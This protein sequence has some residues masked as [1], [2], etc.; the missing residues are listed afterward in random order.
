M[1]PANEPRDQR[2]MGA[3]ALAW[4]GGVVVLLSAFLPEGGIPI[5]GRTFR[6]ILPEEWPQPW[7]GESP[8]Q[9]VPRW[10]PEDVSALLAR[11]DS[12]WHA[13]TQAP[14]MEGSKLPVEQAN[15]AE[16]AQDP[17]VLPMIQGA[18]DSVALTPNTS[19][20]N[21]SQTQ[22][23]PAS[24][25]SQKTRHVAPAA[26]DTEALPSA[27]QLVIPET[28]RPQFS[29]LFSRL[30][31][32]GDVVVLHYGDSQIE[33][34]RISGVMR[35][36]WQ[37]RW[38]GYGP[39]LQAPVPLVQSFALRQR[40]EG[41]WTRHTRYG[42]RDT[43]DAD[44]RYGLLACYAE[45]EGS[46]GEP[47]CLEWGPETRNHGQFARWDGIRI[48]HDSV[49]Q[50]CPVFLDGLPVDT[51]T[52]G[53]PHG[54]LTLPLSLADAAE[55]TAESSMGAG[56]TGD[57]QVC[58]A[59]PP[60]LFALEPLGAGVQW[61]GVPMRGSSGTL[62]RKLDRAQLTQQLRTLSPDLV[63]LQYGGNFVPHCAPDGGAERYARWFSA[64]LRLFKLLL[65]DAALLVIG[66][67]DMAEK[68][69][70]D[71]SP[72]PQ[73]GA[74]RD[75]LK[76]A[77][78]EEGVAYWDLLEVM[79]GI[80]SMPAWVGSTPPLAGPDHVHFT[81][82]GAKRVGTLLD[83]SFLAAYGDWQRHWAQPAPGGLSPRNPPPLPSVAS[84]SLHR[85]LHEKR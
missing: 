53:T 7:R 83:R 24:S 35:D 63:I 13:A 27:L 45:W 18:S 72:F 9:V 11:Y 60:R 19:E 16:R 68:T 57:H 64:Q 52:A 3:L 10:K 42:R 43:T 79:G 2:G 78:A 44:E 38:G 49:E 71:W 48:W 12:G 50:S 81:P 37:R 65:P 58:F 47:A 22:H 30:V 25:A 40:H 66:P 5:A 70:L 62:F 59:A 55:K 46:P 36:A 67:S 31:E 21:T 34:D 28:A 77:A 69:G 82:L 4:V 26:L 29:R 41:P 33:G 20:E 56:N 80:G 85:P 6:V 51:L 39:G 75:A 76:G 14:D 23:G 74:V 61:H 54:T 8:V 17:V 15:P 32:H 73:L 1:N 84:P